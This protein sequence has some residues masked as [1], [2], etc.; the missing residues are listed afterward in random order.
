MNEG[1]PKKTTWEP[2]LITGGG[3]SLSG[4][5]KPPQLSV[6]APS[7]FAEAAPLELVRM[8]QDFLKTAPPDWEKSVVPSVSAR[9]QK[10]IAKWTLDELIKQLTPGIWHRP[11]FASVIVREI[12][13]RARSM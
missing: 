7:T 8:V 11:S 10:H 5:I 6:V 2:R 12:Q 13:S 9:F 4:E 3:S 1:R